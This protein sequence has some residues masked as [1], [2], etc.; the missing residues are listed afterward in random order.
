MFFR[1]IVAFICNVLW[2]NIDLKKEMFTNVSKDI[3][4][5]LIAKIAH[6]TMQATLLYTAVMYWP[7]STTAAASLVSPFFVII[8]SIIFLREFATKQ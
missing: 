7:L 4:C 5:T 2:N 1:A 8:L 3:V 6:G